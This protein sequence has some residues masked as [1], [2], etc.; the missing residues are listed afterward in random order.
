MD[1]DAFDNRLYW[2]SRRGMLELDLLLVPFVTRHYPDLSP[3]QKSTYATLLEQEDWQ[4][5]DWLRGREHPEDPAM[6]RLIET[7]RATDGS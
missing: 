3:E 1:T 2:R 7:I 6:K 4:I 5:F